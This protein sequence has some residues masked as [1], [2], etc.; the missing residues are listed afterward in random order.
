MEPQDQLKCWMVE[1][2]KLKTQADRAVA[3]VRGEDLFRTLDDESNSI[4][5][6]LKHIAGNMRSR[7]VDFLTGDG[8]KPDRNRDAEFI[9]DTETEES[10][11]AAWEASWKL[12]FEGLQALKP[13]DVAKSV[14]VRGEQ[15]PVPEAVLR[16]MN[17]FSAHIGQIVLLAKHFAGDHW[18]TLSIPR[19]QSGEFDAA[20]R[21]KFSRG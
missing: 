11:K 8:E 20:M 5:V 3:Q 7:W 1:F 6:L 9:V 21:Q 12:L 19:G 2:R 18:Q 16:Q 10:I 14:N 13:E 15:Q 4:A 17:H